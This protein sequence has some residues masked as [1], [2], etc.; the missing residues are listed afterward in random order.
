MA[1]YEIIS[2][3]GFGKAQYATRQRVDAA[4]LLAKKWAHHLL[5]VCS[6][7]DR[8]IAH[9]AMAKLDDFERL[10]PGLGA[11]TTRTAKC[12]PTIAGRACYVRL[13]RVQ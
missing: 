13:E 8:P 5:G 10:A 3:D 12:G 1:L 9:D 6:V 11:G 7:R 2:D 4:T